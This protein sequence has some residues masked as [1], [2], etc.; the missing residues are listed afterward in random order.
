MKVI[1]ANDLANFI[2]KLFNPFY[3]NEKPSLKNEFRIQQ[4]NYFLYMNVNFNVK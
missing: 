2:S 1:P 3:I 4:D